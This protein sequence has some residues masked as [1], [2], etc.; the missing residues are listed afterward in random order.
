MTNFEEI[1]N[2]TTP[3]ELGSFLCNQI[4]CAEC[5]SEI[6]KKCNPLIPGGELGFTRWLEEE[7]EC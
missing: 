2:I 1:K 7:S 6:E 3:K 4:M 5:P